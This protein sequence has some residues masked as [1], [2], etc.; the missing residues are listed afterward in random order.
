M[1]VLEVLTATGEGHLVLVVST[2]AGDVVLDNLVSQIR[3]WDATTLKWVMIQ[4]AGNPNTW[5][6][7]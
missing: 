6:N 3:P 5:E 7:A 4:S 2:S 1:A